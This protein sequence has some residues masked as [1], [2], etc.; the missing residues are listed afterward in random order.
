MKKLPDAEL[1]LMMIVWE[2]GRPVTRAEI[3]EKMDEDR[4]ILPN[5]VLS[6]LTR[7]EK[8]GFVRKERDGKNN[9]YS[10]LVE[11]EPYM[12]EVSKGILDKMFHS[13][14]KNFAA[15]LYDGEEISEEDAAELLEFLEEKLKRK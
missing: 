9:L 6:L 2:A 13:S 4:D 10:A 3:E 15:A 1:E 11:R 12:K 14:L 8:R 7:L 5:T